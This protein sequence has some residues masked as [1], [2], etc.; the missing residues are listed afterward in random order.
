MNAEQVVRTYSDMVYRIAF[1]YMKNEADAEDVYSEVFLSYFK[2]ERSF[3]SEDHRRFWLVRVTINAAK[4]TLTAK[5]YHEEIN[6]EILGAGPANT[7]REDILDL[8]NAISRLPDNYRE[9]ISL[10][11]LDDL[12]VKQIAELIGKT[13]NNVKVMLNRARNSLKTLLEEEYNG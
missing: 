9:V 8:R 7:S 5:E 6:E 1:R 12:P 4:K 2:K 3:E 10:F 11:Y 13:E